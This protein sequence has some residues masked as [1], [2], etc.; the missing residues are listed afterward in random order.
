VFANLLGMALFL[1]WSVS[2]CWIEPQL[3]DVPGASGGA[4]FVWAFGPLKILIAFVLADFVWTA[5]VE[6]RS[7]RGRRL[8]NLV[9]PLLVLFG[10]AATFV[11]D[12]L[13]HGA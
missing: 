3:R 9:V 11:F 13:H 2:C 7:S 5:V 10:W 6:I 12:E 8:K 1:R 4:A